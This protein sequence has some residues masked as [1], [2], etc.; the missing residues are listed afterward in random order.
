MGSLIGSPSLEISEDFQAKQ[1]KG[2]E[3]IDA[4]YIMHVTGALKSLCSNKK[5]RSRS[6]K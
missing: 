6:E 1:Q 3:D 2:T 4:E 5:R